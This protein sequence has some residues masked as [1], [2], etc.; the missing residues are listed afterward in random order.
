MTE[1]W[2]CQIE[3]GSSA[4]VEKRLEDLE[5]GVIDVFAF[6]RLDTTIEKNGIAAGTS[7]GLFGVES[8]R[9]ITKKKRKA[10]GVIASRP[11]RSVCRPLPGAV[12][13]I[14]SIART[15]AGDTRRAWRSSPPRFQT[16]DAS[17]ADSGSSNGP[18]PAVAS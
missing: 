5:I 15:F 14:V 4:T 13:G 3:G 12:S 11:L 2:R 9:A 1:G 16:P 10:D 8:G 7:T 18:S 17:S 6:E